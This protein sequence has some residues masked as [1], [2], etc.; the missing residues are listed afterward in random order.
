M[1]IKKILKFLIFSAVA[2]SL[3]SGCA[4]SQ[5]NLKTSSVSVAE[6]SDNDK[7]SSEI[8]AMDTVMDIT[9]YGKDSE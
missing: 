2:V 6:I 8:F 7:F 4:G 5:S 1:L 9:A 3:F